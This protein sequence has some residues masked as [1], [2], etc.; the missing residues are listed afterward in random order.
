M[1]SAADSV[2]KILSKFSHRNAQLVVSD[3]SIKPAPIGPKINTLNC[4]K[5]LVHKYGLNQCKCYVY[6]EQKGWTYWIWDH[7]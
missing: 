1:C 3:C 6:P 4:P 7:E 5:W 2:S